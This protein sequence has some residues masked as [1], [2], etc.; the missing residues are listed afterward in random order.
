MKYFVRATWRKGKKRTAPTH[1]IQMWVYDEKKD[2]M[3]SKW[4][5]E[6]HIL[7]E[8]VYMM[9]HDIWKWDV[10]TEADAMLELI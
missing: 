1:P 5:T 3:I 10:I 2:L 9:Y 8:V 7:S 4:N 6:M